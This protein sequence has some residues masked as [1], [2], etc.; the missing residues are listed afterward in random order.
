LLADP[1]KTAAGT[2]IEIP[3]AGTRGEVEQWRF[4]V[5]GNEAID[6]GVGALSTTHLQR[7]PRPG[8]NDRTIDVWV[9]QSDGGY[10]A[11]VLYTEPSGN[12]VMMTLDKIS[13]MQ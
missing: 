9:A 11:R 5:R 13:A 7:T 10:P 6:T 3:V 2:E 1:Q 12:T 4:D 8:T